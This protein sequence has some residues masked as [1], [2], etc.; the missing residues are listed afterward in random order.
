MGTCLFS[1]GLTAEILQSSEH[2]RIDKFYVALV[3]NLT[4]L[5]ILVFGAIG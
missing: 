4:G 2:I 3:I 1:V 5:T